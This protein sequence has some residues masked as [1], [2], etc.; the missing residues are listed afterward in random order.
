[1]EVTEPRNTSTV[2]KNTLD[3]FNIR[4]DE[5]EEIKTSQ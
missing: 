1:M 4:L 2:L 5:A 3:G